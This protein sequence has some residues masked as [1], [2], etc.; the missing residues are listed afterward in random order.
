MNAK[1]SFRVSSVTGP[2][3]QVNEPIWL[4][5]HVFLGHMVVE[6]PKID[7]SVILRLAFLA[8]N[9]YPSIQ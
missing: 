2:I 3:Y 7:N 4:M 9:S 5:E 1:S 8:K 6:L